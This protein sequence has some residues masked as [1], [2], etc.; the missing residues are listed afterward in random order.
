MTRSILYPLF[1]L[2][3]L[4]QASLATTLSGV[5]YAAVP[6]GETMT[7]T[8]SGFTGTSNVSFIWT[9]TVTTAGFNVISDSELRVTFPN[10]T[11]STRDHQVLVESPSGAALTLAGSVLEFT[12]TGS[13]P[14]SFPAPTRIIAK[15]G[16]VLQGFPAGVTL[17][18]VE[19]GAVLQSLSGSS[20]N[21][22][23][24]AESG[25]VLDF[26]TVTFSMLSSPTILYSQGATV[27][28]SLPP[29]VNS[30]RQIPPLSLHRGL[31]PFTLGVRLNV[32]V[33]GNGAATVQPNVPFIRHNTSFTVTATPGPGAIFQGW[34]GSIVGTQPVMTASSGTTTRNIVATFTEGHTLETFAGSWGTITPEPALEAYPPGQEIQLT[35][36]PNPGYQFVRWGGDF[37]G[38]TA[39]PLPLAMDSNKTVT[40]VFEPLTPTAGPVVTAVD[41]RAVPVGETITL[42][43]SG[44]T[45][46]TDVDFHWLPYITAAAFTEVSDSELK[47][48]FPT[49]TQNIRDHLI[50]IESPAGTTV[51]LGGNV[52]EIN[53]LEQLPTI[54]PPQQ[55]LAKAGSVL[56]QPPAGTRVVYVESGA[57]LKGAPASSTCVIFAEDG[58]T[59]DFRQVTFSPSS[60]P[61]ILHSPG[62]TILGSLPNPSGGPLGSANRPRQVPPISLSRGI[63]PFTLGVRVNLSTV[64]EG[65]ATVEPGGPFVPHS[66]TLTLTATPAP[67]WLFQGWSGSVNQSTP[68]VTTSSGTSDRNFTATFTNGHNLTTYPGS[69]GGIT[70]DPPGELHAPGTTVEVSAFPLPGY[71]FVKWGGDLADSLENPATLTMDAGKVV[72]AVFEPVSPLP[73]THITSVN[74]PAV[75]IGETLKFS[76]SGFTGTNAVT[77]FHRPFI[78]AAT[79]TVGSD[80]DLQVTFPN[81][82]QPFRERFVL[83]ETPTGSTV[84]LGGSITD[85][86]GVG[87]ATSFPF[88]PRVVVKA[89]SVLNGTHP[90]TGV[91][92][93][94]SGAVFRQVPSISQTGVIFAEDGATL[95]LRGVTFSTT[96]PPLILHSPGTLILGSLP[97]P[98][99]GSLSG[100]IISRQ[101]PPLSLSRN[102]GPFVEG[103][104]LVLNPQ[105]PGTVTVDPVMEFYPPGT[106]ITLTATPTPGN[107]F[108]RWSGG[109]SGT[110][111]PITFTLRSSFPVTARFSERQDFFTGWRQHYFTTA[112]LADPAISGLDADPDGDQ[113]TNAGEYA[114]G[115]DPKA[116][117]AGS[118]IEILPG[119]NP[120]S[121]GTLRLAYTRPANAAD[122][123]Y[124][125]Q[126]RKDTGTWFDGSTGEIT[127][128]TTEEIT[129]PQPNDMERVT[130]LMKFTGL[131]PNSLFFRLTANIGDL[132]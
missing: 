120:H 13:V 52:L 45:G 68:V 82:S 26:R 9:R 105:G 129:T 29:A 104:K 57:V 12:D 65:S 62:T 114:F 27:L 22:V 47:V 126:A 96:S 91:V 117:N 37:A 70:T 50:V 107:H 116:L 71:R 60:P 46:T 98:T 25:A 89:G 16:S 115:T 23:I 87:S 6:V 121:D 4:L 123:T 66:T 61:L 7:F 67:G 113:I 58:A 127:F 51:T 112:E 109:V 99:S 106:P 36:T 122:I 39:N 75:P 79:F 14:N 85:F 49:L 76:G 18:Y 93:V 132:P 34:S 97:A 40:A 33:L 100:P 74:S 59:L 42:T 95:D 32:S 44:F 90:L 72:T 84:T 102:I 125:L 130:L 101:I 56:S 3:A 43:G 11:Q 20:S 77:F 64:G 103:F 108:I 54:P 81:V 92:Y 28:G 24:L 119:S 94:E 1:S 35:A 124:I 15:A 8:G 10:I 17:V 53:G 118:G 55:I 48:T 31:G 19:S 73:R 131:L 128:E 41:H 80:S 78:N 69:W 88:P 21:L 110:A 30:S 86:T 2:A 5:D 63:G 111:N 38:A 83:V